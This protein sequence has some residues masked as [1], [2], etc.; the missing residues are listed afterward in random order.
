MRIYI[1]GIRGFPK[2]QGGAEKHCEELCP[3]LA[4]LGCEITVLARTAFFPKQNRDNRWKGVQFIYCWCPRK[5]GME[6]FIHTF[7]GSLICMSKR[8]DIVHFH[9]MGPAIFIPILKIVGIKTVF[10]YHSINYE[11][12]KWGKFARIVLRAGEFLG[13]KFADKVI[14]ISK[15]IKEFLEKKY[16]RKDLE[17]IPNGVNSPE[18]LPP[19][20]TLKKYTL[21]PKK[22]IF[23]ACRFVP[24][25]GLHNLIGAYKK[26]KNANFKLVI[27]GDAYHETDYSR[28][29]K[30][31][32]KE[33][34]G[35][36][37]TGFVSGRPLQELY[38]NAGLF[39]LPS[40][41]EGLPIA[42]LEAMSYG[43]PVL[44][45][46]IPQNR[47]VSLQDFRYF[48]AGNVEELSV[49]MVELLKMGITEDEK[50]R[51]QEVLQREYDWDKIARRTFEV[52]ESLLN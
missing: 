11:H 25:K 14:V 9:N 16:G 12:Q 46:D 33:T 26:I 7:L 39:V 32:A 41:Y 40:Y 2:I 10:T 47:E 6:A 3:R 18:I 51:I 45:S 31:A 42:L 27:A 38:S 15:A 21:E 24:E 48:K 37:L 19:G 8:P 30:Q 28:R 34:D 5:E 23:T 35:I 13:T 22:Y 4:E 29:I 43:L 52:Y 44:V 20:A 17:F 49:K 50:K 36:I 1:L